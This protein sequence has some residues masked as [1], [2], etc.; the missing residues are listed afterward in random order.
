[1][2]EEILQLKERVVSECNRLNSIIRGRDLHIAQLEELL[3][4][5]PDRL[6]GPPDLLEWEEK[7]DA[8]LAKGYQE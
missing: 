6:I 5:H 7:K 4:A 1:M 2:K 8:L 3:R